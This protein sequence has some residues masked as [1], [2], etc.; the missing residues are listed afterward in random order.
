MTKS[1]TWV[2]QFDGNGAF[3]I[4]CRK[5]SAAMEKRDWLIRR[6]LHNDDGPLSD[7]LINTT[8]PPRAP[9]IRHPLNVCMSVW[10]FIGSQ[11]VPE[12]F[13]DVFKAY[14]LVYAHCTNAY[15]QFLANGVSNAVAGRV[16]ADMDEFDPAVKPYVL[17]KRIRNK[18]KLL[19]V[20]GTDKRH[21][22]DVAFETIKL[23][24][25]D[26]FLIVKLGSYYPFDEGTIPPNT[27]VIREDMKSLAPL[28]AA[29]DVLLN[30]VR[31]VGPGMPVVEALAMGLPVVSTAVP[32]I[33]EM[34]ALTSD[35]L[36]V[37]DAPL[38]YAGVHHIHKD[39]VPYWHNPDPEQF[40]DAIDQMSRTSLIE[41]APGGVQAIRESYSWEAVAALMEGYLLS[42]K[43]DRV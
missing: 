33:V 16:G 18:T 40:A 12:S 38:E 21:G 34:R 24:Q 1:I 8:Y 5:L 13:I 31:A 36:H 11:A 25:D 14:D 41:K 3:P 9:N 39:C 15:T 42:M 27:M 32:D 4:I 6:N 19:F 35:F 22:L 2:G 29:C 17:P 30:P 28:Y 43:K 37:I 7:I 26:F 20:G 10:E 23:L